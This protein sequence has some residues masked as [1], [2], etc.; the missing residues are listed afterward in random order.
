MLPREFRAG[1]RP[2]PASVIM[3]ADDNLSYPQRLS[4]FNCMQSD[5]YASLSDHGD[6]PGRSC[7]CTVRIGRIATRH[8]LISKYNY[9]GQ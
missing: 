2:V 9:L 1:N 6:G 8:G 3:P 4:R 7:D 5:L